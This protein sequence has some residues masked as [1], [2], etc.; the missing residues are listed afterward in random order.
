DQRDQ[1]HP[2]DDQEDLPPLADDE[3]EPAQQRGDDR[4]DAAHALHDV[5]DPEQ[6]GAV[7]HVDEHG[8]AQHHAE[9]AADPLQDTQCQQR[10]D[11]QRHRAADRGEQ[12]QDDADEQRDAPAHPVGERSRDDL[13]ARGAQEERGDRQLHPRG[14]GAELAGDVREGGDVHVGGERADRAERGEHEDHHRS[15]LAAGAAELLLGGE[16][17]DVGVG[18]VLAHRDRAG[19]GGDRPG[20]RRNRAGRGGGELAG[21]GA[22][23]GG[24][25]VTGGGDLAGAAGGG[26]GGGGGD[27]VLSRV[28]EGGVVGGGGHDAPSGLADDEPGGGSQGSRP[29]RSEQSMNAD[30][31]RTAPPRRQPQ[32]PPP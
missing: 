28:L 4:G 3:D 2:G 31:A 17:R 29:A 19:D 23:A 26:R 22:L 10:L 32:Y 16:L 20:D 11:V 8:A 25:A 5:H 1:G 13:A 7:G 24:G 9:T 30:G 12:A 27:R 14:G 15:D 6:L 21:A 18:R